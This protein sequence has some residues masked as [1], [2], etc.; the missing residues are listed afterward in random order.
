M[1]GRKG[2]FSLRMALR[3][4]FI[5]IITDILRYANLSLLGIAVFGGSRS[6]LGHVP[7]SFD[8][9]F[10]DGKSK[11]ERE[12]R[13]SR[14]KIMTDGTGRRGRRRGLIAGAAVIAM[15][16]GTGAVAATPARAGTG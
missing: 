9:I 6:W 1:G 10:N 15:F 8:A 12:S 14:R 16:C 5:V 2:F 3:S 4:G 11:E 13:A 7:G